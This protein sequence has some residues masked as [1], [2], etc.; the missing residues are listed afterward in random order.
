MVFGAGTWDGEAPVLADFSATPSPTCRDWI[1][2]GADHLSRVLRARSCPGSWPWLNSF[3]PG[4][5]ALSGP[6]LP[7][8]G[9]SQSSLLPHDHL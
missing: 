3:L 5:Y 4:P 7:A 2:W 1:T 6:V 8:S 9:G